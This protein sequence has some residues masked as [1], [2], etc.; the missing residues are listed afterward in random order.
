VYNFFC[1]QHILS[2][3]FDVKKLNFIFEIV[4]S[5]TIFGFFFR[6]ISFTNLN[7][8]TLQIVRKVVM[9]FVNIKNW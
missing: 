8:W 2:L 1:E 5:T 4:F 6:S 3:Y 9:D 7:V